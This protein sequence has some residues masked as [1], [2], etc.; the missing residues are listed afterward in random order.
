MSSSPAFW[1]PATVPGIVDGSSPAFCGNAGSV[2]VQ[3]QVQ[4]HEHVD[5]AGH[6]SPAPFDVKEFVR[7]GLRLKDFNSQQLVYTESFIVRTKDFNS[8]ELANT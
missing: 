3:V 4:C 6:A 7:K 1:A 5:H 8:Q 2:Q